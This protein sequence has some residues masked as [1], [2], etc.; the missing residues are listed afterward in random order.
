MELSILTN[1]KIVL[2][3]LDQVDLKM[4]CYKSFIEE[5]EFARPDIAIFERF[6]EKDVSHS[7]LLTYLFSSFP[8]L[9]QKVA[10]KAK[11][12]F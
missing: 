5:T 12:R 7:Y 3:V 8:S 4:T 2:A 11:I 6:T 10:L 9:I 1:C